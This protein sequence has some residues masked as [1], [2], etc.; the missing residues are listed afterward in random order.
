METPGLGAAVSCSWLS[1]WAQTSQSQLCAWS[2]SPCEIG[3]RE[4]CFVERGG[5]GGMHST[6]RRRGK[7]CGASG[8]ELPGSECF[9]TSGS[10]PF[11]GPAM[12]SALE[13]RELASFLFSLFP[14]V[15]KPVDLFLTTKCSVAKT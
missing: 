13:F 2:R 8:D 4:S 15:F 9:S 7:T 1:H 14:F 3:K 10:N 11:S 5:W 12:F 6:E